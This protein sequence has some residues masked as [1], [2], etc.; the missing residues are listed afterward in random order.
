MEHLELE[1]EIIF[2]GSGVLMR[3]LQNHHVQ[4]TREILADQGYDGAMLGR[5]EAILRKRQLRSDPEVQCFEDA[6]CLVFLETQFHDLAHRLGEDKMVE[7]L[8]RTLVKMSPHGKRAA[9]EVA[10]PAGESALLAKVL[11]YCALLAKR[12]TDWQ[13]CTGKVHPRRKV[14]S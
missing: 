12:T 6:L 9:T 10:L 4:R 14:H 3:E 8:R 1:S 11:W 2:G 5:V 13:K 7:V